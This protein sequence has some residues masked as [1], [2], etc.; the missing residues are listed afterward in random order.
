LV[1]VAVWVALT[2]LLWRLWRYAYKK[3]GAW[4]FI[5]TPV[6]VFVA[7]VW[8]AASF[9]YGGGRKYYYDAEVERLCA[10]DGGFKVYETVR[11]PAERF[12]EYGDIHFPLRD[13]ATTETDYFWVWEPATI[14]SGNPEILKDSYRIGRMSD[15]KTLGTA[16]SYA[17]LGGDLP[18][19]S[20]PLTTFRCPPER[21]VDLKKHVFFDET[22]EKQAS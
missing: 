10:I 14:R 19:V 11:L 21:L 3:A 13:Y 12:D 7:F 17:R 5:I 4:N 9:W 16:I 20:V 15:G 18:W 6:F 8:L 22:V 2:C 1:A